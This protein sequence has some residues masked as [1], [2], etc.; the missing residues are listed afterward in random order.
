MFQ[1]EYRWG[2]NGEPGGGG[3]IR[4]SYGN[5]VNGFSRSLG[6]ETSVLAEFW[7]LRDGLILATQL[8]IWNL[9]VE[10]DA[11]VVVDLINSNSQTNAVYTTL[12]VDCRLLVNRIPL[13]RVSHVFRE[14][15]CCADALANNGNTMEGYFCVF[16]F[17][18]PFVKEFLCSYVNGVNHCR[19]SAA[20]LASLA[21]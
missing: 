13:A 15:N 1:V 5:W 10:L 3:L 20:N 16:N 7:A 21:S 12:L 19:L 17:A 4:D 8:G 11:K 9:E 2:F 14:E 18:P 6:F